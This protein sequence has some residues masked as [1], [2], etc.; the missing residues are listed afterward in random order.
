MELKDVISTGRLYKAGFTHCGT[1][2]SK[3]PDRGNRPR[4]SK[5]LT[6]G[7]TVRCGALITS[8]FCS[9]WLS[10]G[11]VDEISG[12]RRVIDVTVELSLVE[13][14]VGE[15]FHRSIVVWEGLKRDV[16]SLHRWCPYCYSYGTKGERHPSPMDSMPHSPI[17]ASTDAISEI[18]RGIAAIITLVPRYLVGMRRRLGCWSEIWRV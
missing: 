1:A 8:Q 15:G 18:H 17:C 2:K 13:G 12:M 14:I 11:Q 6:R 16:E 3:I 5:L 7:C 10:S 4:R 9:C